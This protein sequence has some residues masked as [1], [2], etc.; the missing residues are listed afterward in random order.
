M[1]SSFFNLLE[2]YI[3]ARLIVPTT[4]GRRPQRHMKLRLP[5]SYGNA[6]EFA[7]AMVDRAITL[8]AQNYFKIDQQ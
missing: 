8:K 3:S 1:A 2:D 4:P 5:L 7:A 6:Y